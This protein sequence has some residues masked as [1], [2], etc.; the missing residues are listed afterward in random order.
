MKGEVSLFKRAIA[1]FLGLVV[2][3]GSTTVAV[4][5][6]KGKAKDPNEKKKREELKSVYKNWIEQDVSYIIT[7]EERK[8][9]KTL[10]T[11]EERDQ[12][13]EQFWLRR[14]PDPDTTENE[15]KEQYYERIQ[16]ANEKFASG[17]PGWKTDRGP[18]LHNVRQARRDRVSPGG[19][20]LRA[21]FV[22]RRA[23]TPRPTLLKSGGIATSKGSGP[24]SR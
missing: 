14:D 18:N 22:S 11:D 5:Q 15:Y 6:E 17:I 1:V 16:Y 9:F 7:D 23:G 8:A 13:I 4:A 21:A 2:A 20:P 12:F 10:K 24:T 3:I 19:R